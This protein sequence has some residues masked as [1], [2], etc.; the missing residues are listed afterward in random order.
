MT[1]SELL[2]QIF[3]AIPQTGARIFRNNVGLGLMIQHKNPVSKQAI[4]EGCIKYA[5]RMGGSAYRLHFGLR[6]GSGDGIGWTR[7]GR[8][9]S[10][11]AKTERG[12]VTDEQANWQEQVN[13]AGGI[14]II[15]RSLQEVIDV[16]K[17]G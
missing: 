14:G 3:L 15:A 4:I 2:K 13:A 17:L 8:F 16:L 6:E 10:I 9:L 12:K 11:E 7:D 5:E 1:E